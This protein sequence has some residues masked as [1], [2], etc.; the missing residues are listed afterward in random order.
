[1]TRHG[2]DALNVMKLM[3]MKKFTGPAAVSALSILLMLLFVLSPAPA[4][5][6]DGGAI[7]Q[8]EAGQETNAQTR[9][10]I[11]RLNLTADQI[12]R[13][14]AIREQNKEERQAIALHV[15]QAQRALEQ[16]IYFDNADEATVEQRSRELA[17][18]QAEATRMRA[19]TELNIRRVLTPEQLNTLRS[20]RQQARAA[21]RE[22]R[23][24]KREE[25]LMGQPLRPD[26]LNRR[27][28][29]PLPDGGPAKPASIP[30]ERPALKP[31]GRRR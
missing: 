13:I 30:R 2:N 26:R 28:N 12:E 27:Q 22:K 23:L 9:D 21:E 3:S 14:K 5:A 7:Q 29:A 1:M 17:A 18:A 20:L 31:Q 16:A 4:L 11:T 24:Q 8:G 15:R 10:V 6:Q 19:L 25:R